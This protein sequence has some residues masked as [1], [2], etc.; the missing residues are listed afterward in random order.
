MSKQR[1]ST[2]IGG[3]ILGGGL[4]L[5]L[6]VMLFGGGAMFSHTY[7]AMVFFDRSIAGLQVGAPVSFRGVRVGTVKRI[8]LQ[9]NSNDFTARIPVYLDLN[10]GDLEIAGQN[11]LDIPELAKRGLRAQLQVQSLVTG[12]LM[13]EL[14]FQP[15]V[16]ARTVGGGDVPEIP[17]VPSQMDQLKD[18]VSQLQIADTL[19][20]VHRAVESIDKLASNANVQLQRMG[21]TVVTVGTGAGQLMA[22]GQGTIGHLDG[23]LTAT[24]SE[25][26]AL[27]EATRQQV[28]GRGRDMAALM[29]K[30]NATAARIDSLTA[31]LNDMTAARSPLRTDV[32]SGMRDLSASAASIRSFTRQIER[33]PNALLMGTTNR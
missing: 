21:D 12:Q 3:F 17:S 24:L 15:G 27:S 20:A 23:E 19:A 6:G 11:R 28:D 32:E 14:D 25:L 5:A 1:S 2:V 4:L 30:L 33:N 10:P 18:A 8:A 13:V 9:V 29:V 26:R 7:P 22:Q 31:N 16:S